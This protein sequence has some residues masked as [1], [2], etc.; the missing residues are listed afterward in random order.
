M[1]RVKLLIQFVLGW[2]PYGEKINYF[3]Q[4]LQNSHSE[5]HIASRVLHLAKELKKLDTRFPL[6]GKSVV[7]VG[8]GWYPI[9]PFM[10]YLFGVQQCY[11]YDHV[12][13]IRPELVK[14]LVTSIK[15]KLAEVAAITG[16]PLDLLQERV[17][18]WQS[19]KS[20]DEFL[21]AANVTYFAP[22]DA[23]ATGL[24]NHSVD[25]VY[26]YAVLA[27]L[28]RPLLVLLI[29][30][31]KRILKPDG[32]MYHY[33]G[34][35]DPFKGFDKNISNINFLKHSESWWSFFVNN[36]I[37][38][39]NRFRERQ[40]IDVFESCGARLVWKESA[41]NYDDVERLKTMKVDSSFAGFTREELAIYLTRLLLTVPQ[42]ST[43]ANLV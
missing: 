9:N 32:C 19:C 41:C 36:K 23:T 31:S 40:F 4:R 42:S 20:T 10:L 21:A 25:L 43:G 30:E 13:H 7:E 5:S 2:I 18:R 33:I 1:W 3:L 27:H 39:N 24:P 15:A 37:N 38:Y 17:A 8:T 34:M 11:T 28:T 29:E 14:M 6:N 26:S 22:A 35:Q 16:L 12:R